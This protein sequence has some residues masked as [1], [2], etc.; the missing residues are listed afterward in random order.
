[1]PSRAQRCTSAPPRPLK[2]RPLT[3]RDGKIVSVTK[4]GAVDAGAVKV[5]LQGKHV[6]PSFIEPYG[7]YGMPE[8]ERSRGSWNDPPQ[9]ESETKG[10]FGWNQAIR[11]E[12]DASALF[13]INA[14]QAKALREAGYG[15][16]STHHHDGIS[17]GSAAVVSLGETNDNAVLLKRG[18]AHHLSFSKGS[19]QQNYPNSR[20][21]TMALLRQTYLDADWYGQQQGEESNL[22]LEAWA[23]LQD[24]PQIFEVSNWQ[25][26]LRA[27]KVGDEF[28]KQYVIRG[29]GDEYQRLVPLRASGA[30]FILPLTFPK[31]YD[32]SDPFAADLVSLAQLRHWERAPGNVAAVAGAGIPFVLTADGLEKPT[33]LHDAMRKAIE[34]GADAATVFAALTTGPAELLG[35]DD[36]VGTLEKGKLASFIVTDKD[37][38]KEKATVYQNWVRGEAF[39]LKPLQSV[40]LASGYAITVDGTPFTAKV[41]GAPGD[42]KMKMM[43]EGD[44]TGTD[45][46]FSESGGVL[47]LRFRTSDS[48]NFYRINA[49]RDGES[50]TGTGRDP[51]GKLVTFTATPTEGDAEDKKEEEK[52]DNE[53]PDYKSRLTYPNIAYG[54]TEMP[55]AGTVLFRN[56]T[57]W[58]NETDGILEETD[59]LITDGKITG[60][61]KGLS[62]RNATEVDAT[63]MHLTSGIIDE[64]SHIALSAVNESSESSTA[65]VRMADVVDAV[66]ENIYRQ[67]AGG[68]TTS[69]LLHGSA[70]PIGG[71]SALVKL[72]WG[73][74]PQ[75]MMF[76]GARPLHQVCL[77]ENVKQSNWGDANRVR[78]PRPAWASSRSSKTTS[79]ALRS[80]A[81][82]KR[83][84]RRCAGIWNSRPYWKSSTAN[85]SSPATATSRARSICLWSW[86]SATTS[87]ST[88]SPTSWKGTRWRIR[89]PSTGPRAL[90][91]PTGGPISTRST[92]PSP[93]MA[94]LCTSRGSSPPS[95]PTTPR[96]PAASIRRPERPCS[97]AVSARRKPGSSSPSTPPKCCTSTTGLAASRPVRTPTWYSGT[98]TP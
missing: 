44:T 63:G 4:A 90:P 65:E 69:Q 96:W 48:T 2:T 80:T 36:M 45:V 6:Y 29:G 58:T 73:A 54:L 62:A 66:D 40:A 9:Y 3:I 25:D 13:T 31:T 16:V 68:V 21:G 59:V 33:D 88:P 64:H 28:G 41:T 11:P 27:D 24:I 22:S 77:G 37:P 50:Y 47:T 1:M 53:R 67:L 34:A 61:G 19:S 70:N 93:T 84:G 39:E 23:E 98:I 92:K 76:E 32:V 86:P 18:V 35:I 5:D 81:K 20:M 55:E 8:A 56:A 79:A 12:T 17:R 43:V 57:V 85:A 87:A 82:Q 72:R 83:R 42:Q 78:Y 89:W 74:T 91:S 15:T 46:T 97:S 75:E 14:K 51:D 95:T 38:F 94:P 30:T 60:V 71:Q 7:D 10:A 52:D 26:A 49:T